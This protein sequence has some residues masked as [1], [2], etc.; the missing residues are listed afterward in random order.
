MWLMPIR[1]TTPVHGMFQKGNK[2]SKSTKTD[3]Q[4]RFEFLC[5]P[6]DTWWVGPSPQE[7]AHDDIPPAAEPLVVSDETA[8]LEI[9]VRV[10]RGLCLQGRVLDSL[11]RPVSWAHVRAGH[12][13]GNAWVS[14]MADENGRFSIG[15][16]IAGV[17][18]LQAMLPGHAAPSEI[19]ESEAGR[20]EIELRMVEGGSIAGVVVDS[21]TGESCEVSIDIVP[22]DAAVKGYSS[23]GSGA[24]GFRFDGL[25][26]GIYTV[27][28]DA[29]DGRI[30][31]LSGVEIL[32]GTHIEDMRIEIAPAAQLLVRYSGAAEYASFLIYRD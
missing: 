22:S 19:V 27:V 13:T 31:V 15:P 3:A 7:T 24:E 9:V 12:T 23:T 30:G 28:A 21:G 29:G 8:V 26:P 2:P 10:A 20:S 6:A 4:G 16:L 25:A 18:S 11:D 1:M 17:W 32:S 14:A 5:V